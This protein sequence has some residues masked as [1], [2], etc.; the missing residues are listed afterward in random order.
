MLLSPN[1][2]QYGIL[3]LKIQKTIPGEGYHTWHYED[4]IQKT[5]DRI[6]TFILYLND[7]EDGGETEFLYYPKRIKPEQGK[8]ILW[9]AGYT[10]THR[11]NQPLSGEKYILTSWL[12]FTQ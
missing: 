6:A 9:P 4:A 8:L 12:E 5:R 1:T 11:G 10:H 2:P 7:V 3:T